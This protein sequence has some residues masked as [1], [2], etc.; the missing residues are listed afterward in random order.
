MKRFV[1]GVCCFLAVVTLAGTPAARAAED[2]PKGVPTGAQ[3]ARV[4]GYIDGDTFKAR[5][6]DKTEIVTLIGLD[7]PGEKECFSEESVAHLRALLPKKAT[8]YLEQDRDNRDG[9]N[10][11]PRFVWI[12]GEKD[13]KAILVNTK[14]VRDGYAALG[15]SAPTGRYAANLAKADQQAQDAERGIYGACYTPNG[16][17]VGTR[18]RNDI[19]ETGGA[20]R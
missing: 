2:V 18:P 15:T 4:W 14:Q 17:W 12:A 19:R 6:G 11:L 13:A 9:E 10:R 8:I 7:A 5:I 1:L 20:R 16:E 3:E